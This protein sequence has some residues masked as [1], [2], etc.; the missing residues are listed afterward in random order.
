M[1]MEDELFKPDDAYRIPSIGK[2]SDNPATVI[3]NMVPYLSLDP[4]RHALR[5]LKVG[6]KWLEA[7]DG[8]RFIRYPRE[9]FMPDIPGGSYRCVK[10]GKDWLLVAQVEQL[11]FPGLDPF[12][13]MPPKAV[14]DLRFDADG[15]TGIGVLLFKLAGHDVALSHVYAGDLPPGQYKVTTGEQKSVVLFQGDYSVGIMPLS[16]ELLR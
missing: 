5:Y 11:E 3:K 14:F 10:D 15:H 16:P 7:T 1:P 9:K 13:A 4:E 6:A 2:S 12:L 8:H